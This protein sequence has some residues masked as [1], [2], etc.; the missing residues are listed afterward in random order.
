M[1]KRIICSFLFSVIFFQMYAQYSWTE[2]EVYM[3]NGEVLKGYASLPME[4][5]NVNAMNPF[6]KS[7]ERVKYRP[8][9]KSK[10]IKY[11]AHLVDSILFTVTYK[12]KIN[13]DWIE[14]TR[15]AKYIPVYLDKKKKKQGFAELIVDGKVKLVGR[16]VMYTSTT[17]VHHGTTVS[18]GGELITFPPI[19]N[20]HSGTHNNLLVVREGHKAIKINHVSLFK[21]FKK[22]ASEFFSDCQSLVSKIENKEFKKEDLIAIVE[23]YNSNCAK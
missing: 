4:N 1:I 5:A 21:A 14:K 11:D 18:A 17:T 23:Y 22:R 19:Y 2:A 6:G 9:K 13:K 8:D 20:H 16:T 10:K 7:K 3:K 15:I 12:E